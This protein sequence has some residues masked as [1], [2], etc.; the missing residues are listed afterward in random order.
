[1]MMKKLH[2]IW[3]LDGTLINS[4]QEV[5]ESLIKSV[6]QAGI[7]EDKQKSK[8][9]VGPTV[10]KILDNAFGEDGITKEKKKE[11]ISLFRNNYDNC[12]FNNTPSFDGIQEILENEQYVHHIITNK[13]DLAT[14]RILEKLGWNRYFT[15][16]ITPYSFMKSTDDKRKTKSELFSI[17]IKKYSNENF[18]SIGDMDTDIKAAQENNITAI[19]VLWGTGNRF[20][21]ESCGCTIIAEKVDELKEILK[22][23]NEKYY[24]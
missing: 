10:D 13:P 22:K 18:V 15:S 2:I 7:S 14:N 4:E 12:G 8:F 20:E 3:D 19:G 6:R 5:L 16:V 17:C 21:L 23:Y 24:E 1:M 11:I 9:R